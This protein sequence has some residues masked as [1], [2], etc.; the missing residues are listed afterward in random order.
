MAA[1]HSDRTPRTK[2]H[3]TISAE[4]KGTYADYRRLLEFYGEADDTQ[5]REILMGW[6]DNENAVTVR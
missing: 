6:I 1:T 5:A 2:T 3:L 4:K